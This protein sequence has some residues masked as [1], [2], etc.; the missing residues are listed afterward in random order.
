MIS[1]KYTICESND[2]RG[3][4][5]Q[6]AAEYLGDVKNQEVLYSLQAQV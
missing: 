2:K 4:T 3:S 5:L 6:A 1:G